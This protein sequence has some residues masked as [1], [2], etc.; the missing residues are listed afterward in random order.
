MRERARARATPGSIIFVFN[1]SGARGL[2]RGIN[3]EREKR[4]REERRR[5]ESE[6]EGG[7][8]RASEEREREREREGGKKRGISGEG[9]GAS[10]LV[11]IPL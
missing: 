8:E 1:H 11:A 4:M 3:K 7:R 10:V 9:R 5:R 2:I 6:R